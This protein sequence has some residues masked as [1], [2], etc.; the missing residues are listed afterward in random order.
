MP[1]IYLGYFSY[2]YLLCSV[3]LTED[4]QLTV[5]GPTDFG[6][7]AYQS[8]SLCYLDLPGIYLNN[9]ECIV[10][11]QK[12]FC[13][14]GSKKL[15]CSYL[16][17]WMRQ[18]TCQNEAGLRPWAQCR[19]MEALCRTLVR[20]LRYLHPLMLPLRLAAVTLRGHLNKLFLFNRE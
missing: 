1:F 7:S 15:Y 8:T 16:R 3:F 18:G 4:W 19:K 12:V 6:L 11:L 13:C 9:W 14:S 20:R 2:P 5:I 17:I 10:T